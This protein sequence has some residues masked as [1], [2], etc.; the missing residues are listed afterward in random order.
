MTG[1]PQA[2]SDTRQAAGYCRLAGMFECFLRSGGLGRSPGICRSERR[3]SNYRWSAE[4]VAEGQ[5]EPERSETPARAND[6]PAP[7]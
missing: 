2:R 1:K 5:V 7:R 4:G 3:F 6:K